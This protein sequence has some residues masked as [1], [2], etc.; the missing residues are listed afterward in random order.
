MININKF[1]IIETSFLWFLKM[2]D[3]TND[4][5]KTS[6]KICMKLRDR[7]PQIPY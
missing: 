5:T 7:V 3:A 4:N 6:I 1:E 2:N